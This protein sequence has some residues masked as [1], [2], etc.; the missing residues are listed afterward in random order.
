MICWTCSS[1]AWSTLIVA[2]ADET[3][4]AGDSP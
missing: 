2:L 1:V 4:T 3:W